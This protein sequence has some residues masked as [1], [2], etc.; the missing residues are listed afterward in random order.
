MFSQSALSRNKQ[1]QFSLPNLNL[2]HSRHKVGILPG[3]PIM[4]QHDGLQNFATRAQIIAPEMLD[5]DLPYFVPPTFRFLFY[6]FPLCRLVPGLLSEDSQAETQII[7]WN[8]SWYGTRQMIWGVERFCDVVTWF[9]VSPGTLSAGNS[10]GQ[11]LRAHKIPGMPCSFLEPLWRSHGARFLRLGRPISDGHPSSG[12]RP[13]LLN[14]ITTLGVYCL[15]LS[16]RLQCNKVILL[17]CRTARSNSEHEPT[18]LVNFDFPLV[19]YADK[20]NPELIDHQVR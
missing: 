20:R 9:W 19:R 12:K 2:L 18:S 7:N 11:H 8:T 15:L 3:R 5:L 1:C 6:L 17:L 4:V 10:S 16:L 14:Q 13:Y